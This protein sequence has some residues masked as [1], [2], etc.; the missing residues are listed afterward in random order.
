[1]IGCFSRKRVA[2][3]PSVPTDFSMKERRKI[4]IVTVVGIFTG[5]LDQNRCRDYWRSWC[6]G[7]KWNPIKIGRRLSF[8]G[9]VIFTHA[10]VYLPDTT[11]NFKVNLLSV[12]LE[13]IFSNF[14]RHPT[15]RK[16][17]KTDREKR[18]SF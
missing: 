6:N 7:N 11:D 16:T 14:S 9:S 13:P 5:I 17:K 2:N 3:F 8:I 12:N 18:A 4:E 10:W 15:T 1:M